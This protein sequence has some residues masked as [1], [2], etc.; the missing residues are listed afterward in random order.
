MKQVI[1]MFINF[2]IF[3]KKNLKFKKSWIKIDNS[4]ESRNSQNQWYQ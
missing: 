4:N 2:Y 3:Q 1:K